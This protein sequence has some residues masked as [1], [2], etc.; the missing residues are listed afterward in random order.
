MKRGD[1]V[2]VDW[3]LSRP[4]GSNRLSKPR[5]PLVIQNDADNGRLTNTILAMVTSVTRR[6]TEPTQLLIEIATPDGRLTS[7]RQDSVVNCVNL[8]TLEQSKILHVIGHGS[9]AVMD[10]VNDCLKAELEL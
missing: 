6:S 5:P 9:T 3:P 4:Q 1:I 10:Q 8:M 2:I 7:L